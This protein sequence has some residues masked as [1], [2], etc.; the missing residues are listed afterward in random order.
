MGLKSVKKEMDS[1]ICYIYSISNGSV[2]LKEFTSIS[3]EDEEGR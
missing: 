2:K 1:G 3:Q